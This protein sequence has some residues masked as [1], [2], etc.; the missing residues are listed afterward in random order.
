MASKNNND[1]NTSR[2]ADTVICESL[3]V[4][5]NDKKT[6]A[7]LYVANEILRRS[8]KAARRYKVCGL[9]KAQESQGVYEDIM[10]CVTIGSSKKTEII[11]K[12]VNEYTKKDD[13]IEKLI[14]ESSKLL[15]EMRLKIEDAHNAACAMSN[16][17]ENK[18]LPKTGKSTK[19]G[20]KADVHEDLQ[21]I[22]QK[23]KE[24]NEKGQNAFDSSVTIAGIQTFTNTH[25]LNDFMAKLS[26]AM[27][28]FKSTVEQNITSTSG[29]VTVCRE[30]LNVIEEELAQVVCDKKTEAVKYQGLEDVID[31][32]CKGKYN[33][34]LLDLC[35]ET[36][37]CYD[38]DHDN[39]DAR[40]KGRL[41]KRQT[42][43]R[44]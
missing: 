40:K 16:C 11:Q 3:K 19:D 15:N 35:R 34:D 30:E 18:I 20:E 24:L 13:E 9:D 10:S 22:L 12:N 25:S 37:D 5:K 2:N 32:V 44:D 23:T 29:D 21:K 36:R 1:S 31:Y 4:I 33:D 41:Q 39:Y 27:G 38:A 8:K 6:A 42:I 28:T 7:S 43:D 14:K 26:A 17:F